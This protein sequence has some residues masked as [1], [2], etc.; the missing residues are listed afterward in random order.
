[1]PAKEAEAPKYI[2]KEILKK[3]TDRLEKGIKQLDAKIDDSINRLD[4]KIDRLDAKIDGVE[5]RLESKIDITFQLAKDYTD[6]RFTQLDQKMD[7]M[8]KKL[9]VSVKGIVEM[10]ERT[11]GNLPALKQQVDDHEQ[12]IVKLEERAAL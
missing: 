6:S 10:I 4:A 8:L 5:K 7:K 12:R 11:T 1:M 9:D 3:E 2:T